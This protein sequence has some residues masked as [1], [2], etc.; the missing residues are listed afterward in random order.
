M[1]S[2]RVFLL[3]LGEIQRKAMACK[4]KIMEELL[5]VEATLVYEG[6]IAEKMAPGEYKNMSHW[7]WDMKGGPKIVKG[8]KA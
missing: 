4:K 2:K 3:Q 7:A 6:E 1:T 8:G 5:A